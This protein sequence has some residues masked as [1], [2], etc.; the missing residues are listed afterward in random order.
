MKDLAT[1]QVRYTKAEDQGSGVLGEG[2]K[3]DPEHTED[4]L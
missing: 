4:R 2:G 3:L 1:I